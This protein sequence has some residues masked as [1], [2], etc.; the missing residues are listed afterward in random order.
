MNRLGL[1]ADALRETLLIDSESSS[2]IE[3]ILDAKKAEVVRHARAG[4]IDAARAAYRDLSSAFA[5]NRGDGLQ[6]LC[7]IR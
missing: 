3:P 6:A 7:W 1:T 5:A 4:N 2:S